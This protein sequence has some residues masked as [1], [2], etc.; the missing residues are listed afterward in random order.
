MV[1]SWDRVGTFYFAHSTPT[2]D[3]RIELL[4]AKR[5]GTFS[6][7]AARYFPGWVTRT[8]S[9]NALNFGF[10]YHAALFLADLGRGRHY[11]RIHYTT[12]MR[13]LEITANEEI[14]SRIEIM[15]YISLL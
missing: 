13:E 11:R 15:F 5:P 6:E 3:N 8:F 2:V 4:W 14:L 10:W 9:E 12:L 7:S 1:F